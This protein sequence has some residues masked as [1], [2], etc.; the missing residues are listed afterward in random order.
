MPALLA[1]L[2]SKGLLDQTLVVLDTEFGHGPRTNDNDGR[3][4]HNRTYGIAGGEVDWETEI[5]KPPCDQSTP[6]ATTSGAR[7]VPT[8][9]TSG[10]AI[11]GS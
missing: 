5:S 8:A 10:D 11:P 9:T 2:Q 4:H 6:T 3:E 1:D 7:H